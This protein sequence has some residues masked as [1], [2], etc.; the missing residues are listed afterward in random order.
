MTHFPADTVQ[1]ELFTPVGA[2]PGWTQTM[3]R[4]TQAHHTG[5]WVLA[6]AQYQLAVAQTCDWL[7]PPL[8]AVTDA[9]ADARVCA[10]VS[11]HRC[12]ADL[13]AEG[14]SPEL[15]A[16]TLAQ[17]HMALLLLVQTHPP[18]A[19]WHRAAAWHCRDTHAAV[20]AHWGAHGAHPDLERALRAGCLALNAAPRPLPSVH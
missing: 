14:G 17:A 10:F 3:R 8:S 15:G 9:Q 4:A 20:L 16:L 19:A 12:L 7:H 5:Q 1:S 13:Q 11:S 6:L 2:L 18:S